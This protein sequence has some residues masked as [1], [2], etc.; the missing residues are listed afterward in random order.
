MGIAYH[1]LPAGVEQIKTDLSVR[2]VNRKSYD[3]TSFFLFTEFTMKLTE[4]SKICK[5]ILLH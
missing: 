5:Q 2:G 1:R 3:F 4:S